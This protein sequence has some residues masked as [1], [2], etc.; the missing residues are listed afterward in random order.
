[1]LAKDEARAGELDVALRS[2]AEGLRVVTV[3]LH[4]Y[5]PATVGILL[6]ALGTEDL[7]LAGAS[8]GAHPGGERVE[9][10]APLFPKVE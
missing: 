10:I 6:G 2:L 5:V 9:R 8:Y 3:L 1:V 7:A 4:P